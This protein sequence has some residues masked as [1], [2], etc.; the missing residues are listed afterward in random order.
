MPTIKELIESKK[1][2]EEIVPNLVEQVVT[3]NRV[4]FDVNHWGDV[5][6]VFK[7]PVDPEEDIE[8][9]GIDMRK[10]ADAI[11]AIDNRGM[12]IVGGSP[13]QEL[14]SRGSVY[15]VTVDG[16]TTEY[17]FNEKPKFNVHVAWFAADNG[18]PTRYLE[19]MGIGSR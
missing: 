14:G 15:Y 12:R 1:S 18:D 4:K 10:V 13:E 19:S 8:E 11:E 6:G 7:G 9:Y 16:R 17:Q 3:I 5:F 2:P